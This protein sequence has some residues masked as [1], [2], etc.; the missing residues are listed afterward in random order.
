[1][2]VDARYREEISNLQAA[3]A[4]LLGWHYYFQEELHR[5]RQQ[6]HEVGEANKAWETMYGGVV[7]RQFATE[8]TYRADRQ[9]DKAEIQRLQELLEQANEKK[10]TGAKKK[11]A[12]SPPSA[13]ETRTQKRKREAV[14]AGLV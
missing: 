13:I 14:M 1:M 6:L 7:E 8:A 3:N 2:Q 12:Y 4:H 9:A 5:L 10:Q 11:K